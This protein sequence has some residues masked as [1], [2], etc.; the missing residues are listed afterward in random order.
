MTRLDETMITKDAADTAIDAR[1][2]L[3][4]DVLSLLQDVLGDGTVALHEPVIE[5]DD[6]QSVAAVI[7]SGFVSSVGESIQN[8]ETDL[9]KITGAKRA[10]A[11]VNG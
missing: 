7:K 6:E 1:D 3:I 4:A 2:S 8:F 10:V 11:V 5:S 9:C